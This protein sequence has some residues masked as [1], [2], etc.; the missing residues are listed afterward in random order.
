M[1]REIKGLGAAAKWAVYFYNTLYPLLSLTKSPFH[2]SQ[3]FRP[4]SRE[5][6]RCLCL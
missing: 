3:P 5:S 6:A 4:F 2:H 1:G